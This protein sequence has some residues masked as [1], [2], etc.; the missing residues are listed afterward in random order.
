[1]SPETPT[2]VIRLV[3]RVGRRFY[4]HS[5]DGCWW[6]RSYGDCLGRGIFTHRSLGVPRALSVRI[7]MAWCASLN[8]GSMQGQ[9]IRTGALELCRLCQ[10]SGLFVPDM[11]V[12]NSLDVARI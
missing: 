7:E 5:V 1:M 10:I 11:D 6:S 2:R 9:N 4:A 3:V 12:E 8:V